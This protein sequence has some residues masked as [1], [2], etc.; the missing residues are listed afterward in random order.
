MTLENTDKAIADLLGK[1]PEIIESASTHLP[2][3][4]QQ[5]LVYAAFDAKVSI[6]VGIALLVL[7]FITGAVALFSYDSVGSGIV[8][9]IAGI[10]GVIV[11]CG[12][13]SSAYKIEHAP[14]V[15]LLEKVVNYSKCKG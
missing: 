11:L 13:I 12:S 2:E 14:K 4:A 5:M 9:I 1:L 15:Y 6:Y 10:I 8:A 3:I 7:A